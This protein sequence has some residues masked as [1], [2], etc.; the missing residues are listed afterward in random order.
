MERFWSKVNKTKT[1]WLWTGAL[2]GKMGYGYFWH[3]QHWVAHRFSW[4]LAHGPIPSNMCILHICDNPL[5]VR[6]A[7]LFIGSKKDNNHD[8][9]KKGRTQWI[10]RARNR[11]LSAQQVREIRKLRAKG[12]M[13]TEIGKLYKVHPTT[14]RGV[15]TG[16]T[17]SS[18][19]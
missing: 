2:R 17:Y 10:G 16:R 4:Q 14:I 12:M 11:M 7:H 5:C 3:K 15:T 1:C 13:H 8:M 9:I 6:P 18:V 19:H